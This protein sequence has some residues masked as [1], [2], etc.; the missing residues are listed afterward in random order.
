MTTTLT[1]EQLDKENMQALQ[2]YKGVTMYLTFKKF[3]NSGDSIFSAKF[4]GYDVIQDCVMDVTNLASTVLA[5]L[6]MP[7][8]Y[9][10]EHNVIKVYN[11]DHVYILNKFKDNNIDTKFIHA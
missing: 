2:G 8:K 6:G 4:Y 1:Q 7:I 9:E 11:Q 5:S 10:F 3:T